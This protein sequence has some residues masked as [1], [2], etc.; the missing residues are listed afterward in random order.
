MTGSFFFLLLFLSLLFSHIL[1][2]L[3]SPG[4]DPLPPSHAH[5]TGDPAF[6]PVG[7]HG[8]PEAASSWTRRSRRPPKEPRQRRPPPPPSTLPDPCAWPMDGEPATSA[9]GAA[10][11][12]SSLTL[13]SP[14]RL[15][16]MTAMDAS[17]PAGWWLLDAAARSTNRRPSRCSYRG[18]LHHGQELA[19][20]MLPP[21]PPAAWLQQR[22]ARPEELDLEDW[23]W[24]GPDCFSEIFAGT[25]LHL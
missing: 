2:L 13:H 8:V 14:T 16:S 20:E 11:P 23:P 6:P 15:P 21:P 3:F 4:G 18:R 10:P 12:S 19:A 5:P 24:Q 25:K 7:G 9:T 17:S 1:S 22:Q